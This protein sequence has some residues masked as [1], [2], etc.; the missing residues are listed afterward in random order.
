MVTLFEFSSHMSS[1]R[2][3]YRFHE[4]MHT[5]YTMCLAQCL[6]QKRCFILD[7]LDVK[8]NSHG[9][10]RKQPLSYPQPGTQD[11]KDWKRWIE[12]GLTDAMRTDDEM[13][14]GRETVI[15]VKSGPYCSPVLWL[16]ALV[17]PL[18]RWW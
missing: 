15:G 13:E 9:H 16:V 2:S 18:T 17:Y 7:N 11:E 6:T 12:E 3:W 5:R 4:I 14:L 1:V 8:S 10:L